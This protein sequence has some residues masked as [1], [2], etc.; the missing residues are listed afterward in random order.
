MVGAGVTLGRVELSFAP[1]P[2][3]RLRQSLRKGGCS[4]HHPGTTLGGTE[5]LET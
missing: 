1:F 3:V 2:Q 5:T 4:L